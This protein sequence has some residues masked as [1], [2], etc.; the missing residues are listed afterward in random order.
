MEEVYRE[1]QSK[2]YT[3]YLDVLKLDW[4]FSQKQEYKKSI[5]EGNRRYFLGK[6]TPEPKNTTKS[7]SAT[8]TIGI[9][10]TTK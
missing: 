2:I 8:T 6:T 4:H 9:I 1:E 5:N 7:T 10:T 3:H